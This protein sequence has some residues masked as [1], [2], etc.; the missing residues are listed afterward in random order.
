MKIQLVNYSG[1][2]LEELPPKTTV[3]ELLEMAKKRQEESEAEED[4]LLAEEKSELE[5]KCFLFTYNSKHKV[6]MLVEEVVKG[7]DENNIR[8]K[9]ISLIINGEGN[10]DFRHR[11]LHSNESFRQYET[12]DTVEVSSTVYYNLFNK[13]DKLRKAV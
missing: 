8:G 2:Q 6:V 11:E 7:I 10:F 12:R 3:A 1:Y 9:V 5:G 4:A 13:F